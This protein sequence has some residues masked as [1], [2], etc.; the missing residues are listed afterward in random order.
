MNHRI[1]F[2]IVALIAALL[3][4]VAIGYP[5]WGCGGRI[6][7]PFCTQFDLYT[8][9]G[10][11]LM[12]AAIL[13]TTAAFFLIILYAKGAR[14]ASVVAAVL[15]VLSAL[16]AIVGLFYYLGSTQF[17]SAIIATMAMSFTI[18]LAVILIIYTI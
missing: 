3:F 14:W 17:L 9:T 12:T 7:G 1:G 8:I 2:I 16:L 18:T 11:L 10:S 15:T 4:Y 5:G 13:V 6:L